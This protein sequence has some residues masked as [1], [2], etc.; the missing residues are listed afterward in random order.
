[1]GLKD[2]PCTGSTAAA[3]AGVRDKGLEP[4]AKAVRSAQA[5]FCDEVTDG[6][7]PPKCQD[8]CMQHS[9]E[10]RLSFGLLFLAVGAQGE[11]AASLPFKVRNALPPAHAPS[12]VCLD[13]CVSICNV[14]SCADT[15]SAV[16]ALPCAYFRCSHLLICDAPRVMSTCR[17][18]WRVPLRPPPLQ[19]LSRL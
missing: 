12:P 19:A 13:F 4:A 7:A 14:L 3:G 18:A 8:A 10:P 2:V 15:C 1:M 5:Y 17:W 9:Q 11:H 6:G 16:M